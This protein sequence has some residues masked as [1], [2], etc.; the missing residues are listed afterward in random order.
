M[1]WAV[2]VVGV[3]ATAL[4]CS[5]AGATEG[6]TTRAYD[7]NAAFGETDA[8]HDG[9]VDHEEFIERITEVFYTADVDRDGSLS[10]AE[11]DAAMVHTESL[12]EADSNE[13]GKLNL[14]EFRRA[15]MRDYERADT[16]RSGT[17]SIE[18]VIVVY[19]GLAKDK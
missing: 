6:P 16:D 12:N 8:N 15:R 4:A 19:Q 7:A 5:G 13:D 18:E 14:H 10:P 2:L 11:V 1:R 3:A 17:L 9:A